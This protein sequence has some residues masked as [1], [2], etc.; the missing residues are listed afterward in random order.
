MTG[1]R[2]CNLN[3]PAVLVCPIAIVYEPPLLVLFAGRP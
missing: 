3:S 2:C 1:L